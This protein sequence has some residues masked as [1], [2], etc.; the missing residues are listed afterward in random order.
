MLS[1]A[2]S[3]SQT[4]L[5]SRRARARPL[6]TRTTRYFC[7][8]QTFGNLL[9]LRH[10]DRDAFRHETSRGFASQGGN[11]N[12]LHRPPRVRSVDVTVPNYVKFRFLSLVS[13]FQ[14]TDVWLFGI[15]GSLLLVQGDSVNMM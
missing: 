12:L 9:Y 5:E 2:C 14:C 4:Q 8:H 10:H 6:S 1:F 13:C 11:R 15:C 3:P 7:W